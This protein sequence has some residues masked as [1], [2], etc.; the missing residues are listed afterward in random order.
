MFELWGLQM[1]PSV[2]VSYPEKIAQRPAAFAEFARMLRDSVRYMKE[3][4]DE[5][6]AAVAR[7]QKIDQAFFPV[8]FSKYAEYPGVLTAQDRKA[9]AK[10]WELAKKFGILQ[11]APEIDR[12]IWK[13]ALE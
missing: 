7:E 11:N 5:V 10:S 1:I 8:L 13:G 12:Y 3:H 2:N 4:P 6:Y 9:I